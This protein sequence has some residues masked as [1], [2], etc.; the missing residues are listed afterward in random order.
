LFEY[1]QPPWSS[2]LNNIQHNQS[3]TEKK[4]EEHDWESEKLANLGF[5][6]VR[7]RILEEAK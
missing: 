6:C 7:W 2:Y 3:A 1:R 4:R 5:G